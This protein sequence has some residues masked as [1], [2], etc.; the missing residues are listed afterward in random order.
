MISFRE[1]LDLPIYKAGRSIT[2]WLYT[3]M[4]VAITILLAVL[5]LQPSAA[6][7]QAYKSYN[8]KQVNNFCFKRNKLKK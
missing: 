3:I 8:L 2:S 7:A 1:K 5:V 6:Q 4:L